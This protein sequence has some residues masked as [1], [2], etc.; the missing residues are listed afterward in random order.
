[1]V[2]VKV[3]VRPSSN[4]E[5]YSH[6]NTLQIQVQVT[7]LVLTYIN[8]PLRTL[9]MP[10]RPHCFLY[11]PGNPISPLILPLRL[12]LRRQQLLPRTPMLAHTLVTPASGGLRLPFVPH[13]N[14]F[15]SATLPLIRLHGLAAQI[16]PVGISREYKVS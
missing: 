7:L 10:R 14:I 11:Y 4:R 12:L 5:E 3:K 13:P 9:C 16:A 6:L 1:M 15:T 2:C 8:S